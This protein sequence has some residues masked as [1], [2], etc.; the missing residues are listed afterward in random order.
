MSNAADSTSQTANVDT[1]EDEVFAEQCTLFCF[2]QERS[3]WNER[4][5]GMLK[6]LRDR[7]AGFERILMRQDETFRVRAN[8]NV[9]YLGTLHAL[10]GSN[11]EFSWTAYDF[12]ET[13]KENTR[14]LFAVRFAAPDIAARFK[15][16]FGTAQRVNRGIMNSLEESDSRV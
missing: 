16:A 8:H 1:D 11:R 9:P 2:S 14:E 4:C 15:A 3:E 13:S 7:K 12:D 10:N 5:F 6:I